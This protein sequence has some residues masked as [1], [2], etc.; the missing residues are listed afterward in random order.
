[1]D[2]ILQSVLLFTP[3]SASPVVQ[4]IVLTLAI[5]GLVCYLD[6]NVLDFLYLVFISLPMIGL[7]RVVWW[8]RLYPRLQLDRLQLFLRFQSKKSVT[9]GVQVSERHLKMAR[10]LMEE[11]QDGGGQGAARGADDSVQ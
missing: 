3:G 11:L 1:M 6:R 2:I 10:Q 8:F 5:I 7:M 9:S 4:S